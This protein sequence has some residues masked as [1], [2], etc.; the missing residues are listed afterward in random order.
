MSS[1]RHL[2]KLIYTDRDRRTNEQSVRFGE[3]GG[4]ASQLSDIVRATLM[5]KI[6][7]N[8]IADIYGA[9]EEIVFMSE[10]N[11]VRASVTLL[12]DRWGSF[13]KQQHDNKN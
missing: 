12:D 9:I 8:V 6:R 7:P 13:L 5:F 2:S 1:F 11:G 10:L 4:D 3:Y